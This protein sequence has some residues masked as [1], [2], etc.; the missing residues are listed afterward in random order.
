MTEQICAHGAKRDAPSWKKD[1][2][3]QVVKLKERCFEDQLV[4]VYAR[5]AIDQEVVLRLGALA[6]D[7]AG[8][9]DEEIPPARAKRCAGSGEE[10]CLSRNKAMICQDLDVGQVKRDH[11]PRRCANS[12]GGGWLETIQGIPARREQCLDNGIQDEYLL[13][14]AL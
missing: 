13:G 4:L 14:Q 5:T 1:R 12:G 8:N 2:T 6:S 11:L 10:Q 9:K 7:E 3:G